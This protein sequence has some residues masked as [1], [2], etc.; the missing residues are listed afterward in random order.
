MSSVTVLVKEPEPSVREAALEILHSEIDEIVQIS[1]SLS[2]S[3]G[4]LKSRLK[5]PFPKTC[6]QCGFIYQAF[7][8]FFYG[9]EEI[10]QGTIS[11]PILN[12][13]FYLHRNCK[14]PCET[15]LVVVFVDRRDDS[16]RG[17][18]RRHLFESCIEV[19]QSTLKIDETAA[20]DIVLTV[21]A[22]QLTTRSQ[23]E[24]GRLR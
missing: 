3:L 14:H 22:N 8:D 11:Y 24:A 12:N 18:R 4:F 10:A 5:T 17:M 1:L 2:K 23:T 20:R 21:L 6:S 15:T 13:D 7:E 19:L 16:I 9:T